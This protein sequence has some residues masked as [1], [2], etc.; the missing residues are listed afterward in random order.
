MLG[1]ATPRHL[2]AAESYF[3]DAALAADGARELVRQGNCGEALA[4][5]AHYHKGVG[6]G[7][8]HLESA[9]ADATWAASNAGKL[10][11]LAQIAYLKRCVVRS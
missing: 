3:R 6:S 8:A 7:Y 5:L 9:A 2:A 1:D 4:Y 10:G 11:D